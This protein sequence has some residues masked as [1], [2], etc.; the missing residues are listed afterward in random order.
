MAH[1]NNNF[2]NLVALFIIL[3]TANSPVSDE[4]GN[5]RQA[6]ADMQ[7]GHVIIVTCTTYLISIFIVKKGE[8][9]ACFQ[10]LV[11]IHIL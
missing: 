6:L 9:Y 5:T 10:E 2:P 8:L 7:A 4:N 11:E 1:R 3:L